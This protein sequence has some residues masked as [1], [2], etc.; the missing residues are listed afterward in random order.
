MKIHLS[1]NAVT[2]SQIGKV[3]SRLYLK[4]SI[5]GLDTPKKNRFCFKNSGRKGSTRNRGQSSG[6]GLHLARQ[7]PG[8]P[9]H[10]G[11]FLTSVSFDINKLKLW[12]LFVEAKMSKEFLKL[13][14]T[15]C[16]WYSVP[17]TVHRIPYSV[18]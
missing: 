18:F 6:K 9:L 14:R 11:L 13:F 16:I 12:N 3:S 4:T 17:D 2:S 8:K 1:E 10:E 7:M 15:N 5:A